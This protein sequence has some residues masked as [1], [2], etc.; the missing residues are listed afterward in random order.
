MALPP[1]KLKKDAIAE[2][3]CEVRFECEESTSLPETVVSKLAEFEPWRQF[4]KVRLAASDIPA[5]L[6]S[7]V[8]N[9]KNQPL[10]VL[11]EENG[12]RQAKI[13]ANVMSYHRLAPYPGWATF[14]PEIDSAVDYL[15]RS[16]QSFR[17][18]RLGF[19]Y[20]NVF[21]EADHGITAVTN[22]NYSVNVAGEELHDPQNLNYRL[23]RSDDHIVQIRIASPE[24]VSGNITGKVQVLA[25]VDVFTPHNFELTDADAAKRWIEDAHTYEKEEFFKLF[26]E[27][28]KQ[29]LVE[30]E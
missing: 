11:R 15:F 21:T 7:Q 10:L 25:D 28:M 17:A 2:A 16:F 18:T 5:S 24:F 6:R 23:V 19:R 22:L 4:A 1:K 29:R 13:G 26:T 12:P 3:L 27:K 8:P 14:K 30:V 9:F 20:V